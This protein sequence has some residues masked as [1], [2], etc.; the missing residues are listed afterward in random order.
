MIFD[1]ILIP[2]SPIQLINIVLLVYCYDLGTPDE[3]ESDYTLPIQLQL[4]FTNDSVV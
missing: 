2:E 3:S 4:Q 1:S